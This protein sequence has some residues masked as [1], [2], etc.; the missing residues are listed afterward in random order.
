MQRSILMLGS[1]LSRGRWLALSVCILALALL[2]APA[3]AAGIQANAPN[4]GTY[5]NPLH[6]QIP[7]DGLVESCADPSIIHG[8]TPG[9]NYWYIYCTTD[10]LNDQDKA[11]GG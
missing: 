6:I 7:G 10:P 11:P 9:D 2:V 1:V 5:T 4:P 3:Q 8:Q